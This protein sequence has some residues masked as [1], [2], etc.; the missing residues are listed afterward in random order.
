MMDGSLFF[1]AD[2]GSHG[3]ELWGSKGKASNTMMIKDIES[4]GA[5][6]SFNEMAGA[7]GKL[8]F[9][10]SNIL[11]TSDGS[12]AGTLPGTDTGLN[13]VTS[14]YGL[15]ANGNKLFFTGYSYA[16]GEELYEGD[17]T[18]GRLNSATGGSVV[19]KNNHSFSATIYPNPASSKAIINITGDTRHINVTLI[20]FC[21]IIQSHLRVHPCNASIV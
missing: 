17:V 2:D 6:P 9:N 20:F 21:S 12:D 3:R 5:G 14:V 16:Y 18:T 8:F 1:T 11:W 13:D 15:L 10:I 7:G 4:G 19:I